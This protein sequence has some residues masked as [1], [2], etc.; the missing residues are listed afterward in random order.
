MT[1]RPSMPALRSVTGLQKHLERMVQERVKSASET[2]EA[3]KKAKDDNITRKR[4]VFT[5]TSFSTFSSLF[6]I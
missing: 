2:A 1:A 5:N 6:F 4:K 3:V